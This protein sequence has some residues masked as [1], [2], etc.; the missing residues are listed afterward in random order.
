MEIYSRCNLQASEKIVPAFNGRK[1][2]FHSASVKAK[3]LVPTW[4]LLVG[5]S[6]LT[7]LTA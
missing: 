4:Q 3:G 1:S 6:D 2:T 5:T 7:E